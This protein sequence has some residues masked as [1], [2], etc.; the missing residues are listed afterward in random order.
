[1][2]RLTHILRCFGRRQD[3]AAL[4]EFGILLPVLLLLF[5]VTIESARTF[6]AYQATISGVR[7][8]TRYL[9]RIAPLNICTSGGSL[10]GFAGQ[11]TAIV[12]QN[13]AGTSFFPASITVN[14]VTPS[15][16]CVAGTYRVSPA[17]VATVTANITIAFPFSGIFTLNGGTLTTKT[18]TVTDQARI[19]GT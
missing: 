15:H 13:A 4:V 3:G 19:F 2:A 6:W 10:N 1:M 16:S 7:D 9:A 5:A 12:E 14:S 17:P 11:V 8:A 18:T